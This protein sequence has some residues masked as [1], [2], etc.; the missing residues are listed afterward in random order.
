MGRSLKGDLRP[1]PCPTV[2]VTLRVLHCIYDDPENPWVGGGGAV[3]A[4][5]LYRRLA[6]RVDVTVATG[7]FPGARDGLVDGVRYRRLGARTPYAWSRAT[8]ARAATH[9]LRRATYDA[10]V[11]DFSAY[12]P[13]VVPRGRAVGVTVHHLSGPTAGARWGR[14]GGALVARVE[15]A[16]LRQGLGRGGVAPGRAFSADSAATAAGLAALVPN[17]RIAVVPA[18]V[19]DDLFTLERC[20]EHY[21]LYLGRL[22]VFQKGLDTLVE[23]VGR[24]AADRP[25]I[26]LRVAGRGRGADRVRALAR[27]LGVASNVRVLGA[28]THE[29]RRALLA[30]A[31]VQVMPSRFEGFG[32]AAAEAMAAGVPLVAAAAGALPEVVALGG[33]DGA[34]APAG[35]VLVPPGDAPALAAA[36][37]RLLDDGA[38]RERLGRA[39]RRSAERFRWDAVADQHLA[40]L[41]RVAAG[42][43]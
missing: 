43:A 30:G 9:L 14:A 38:A 10:A 19:A 35:G 17:A 22:D 23:A 1:P 25:G 21:L 6:G 3:R 42:G 40:F 26:E 37:G 16:L 28:V 39:A 4:R 18:G 2:P 32:M 27:A 41:A 15:R 24:L 7:N 13:I 12:T 33:A 29:E 8:Y 11:F 34:G 5:E 31:A 20:P 36:I